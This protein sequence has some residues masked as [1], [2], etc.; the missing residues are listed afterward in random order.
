MINGDLEVK[1]RFMLTTSVYR[2]CCEANGDGFLKLFVTDEQMKSLTHEKEVIIE[3]SADMP[4]SEQETSGVESTPNQDVAD[5]SQIVQNPTETDAAS[6]INSPESNHSSGT[7]LAIVLLRMLLEPMDLS[8]QTH[9]ASLLLTCLQHVNSVDP[10]FTNLPVI[11]DLFTRLKEDE[12]S[13]LFLDKHFSES[14]FCMIILRCSVT[15]ISTS[16]HMSLA[17]SEE[18][19]VCSR[20]HRYIAT[21]NRFGYVCPEVSVHL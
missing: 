1:S 10:L 18:Q 7:L 17:P 12:K 2:H 20:V 3:T 21:R 13:G 5:A 19:Q 4:P 15:S 9:L 14:V 8:L 11:M 16:L 6:I